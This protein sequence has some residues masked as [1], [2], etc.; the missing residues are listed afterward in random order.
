[1]YTLSPGNIA[2]ILLFYPYFYSKNTLGLM[3]LKTAFPSIYV[4][5]VCLL[6]KSL[7]LLCDNSNIA[8]VLCLSN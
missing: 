2:V 3:T 7:I 6:K 5:S 8:N 4:K 1:M